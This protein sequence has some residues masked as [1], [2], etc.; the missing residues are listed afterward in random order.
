MLPETSIALPW[1]LLEAVAGLHVQQDVG[2]DLL[3]PVARAQH[4]LH[5]AP[6]LLELGLGDVGQ[7]LRLELEPLIDLGLRGDVL[8]DVARLVAQVEHDAVAHR[9]VVLVGVDV[10]AEDLDAASA[11]RS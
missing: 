8:V 6:A 1:P 5:R 7:A 10:R 4:L 9:L 3:K 11:C 2:D